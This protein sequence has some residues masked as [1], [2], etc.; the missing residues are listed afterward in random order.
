MEVTKNKD[1]S[2]GYVINERK[3]IEIDSIFK[4]VSSDIEYSVSC[5][6]GTSINFNSLD[7]LISYPNRKEKQYTSISISNNYSSSIRISLTL[8]NRQYSTISYRVNGDEKE[9]DFYARKIEEVIYSLRQWYS[10]LSVPSFVV[11]VLFI[12]IFSIIAALLLSSFGIL[13]ADTS[14]YIALP[15]TIVNTFIYDKVRQNLFPV[16]TFELGDGIDRA[17]FKNT[18][19]A[20]ILVS[21]FLTGIVGYLV[22]QLPS[23]IGN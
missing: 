11:H 7:E 23:F 17:K 12:S 4:E 15:I 16:A 8:S 10:F 21:I 19:R 3:L 22:N 2:I 18:L 20:G 5:L 13:T 14:I 6:D 9:V 1:I